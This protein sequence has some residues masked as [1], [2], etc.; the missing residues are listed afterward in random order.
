ME[1][2]ISFICIS[3]VKRDEF[4]DPGDINTPLIDR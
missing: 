4:N 3:S 2:Y 1:S